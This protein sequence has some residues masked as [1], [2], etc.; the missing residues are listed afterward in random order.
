VFNYDIQ[1]RE[2]VRQNKII[3]EDIITAPEIIPL[4]PGQPPDARDLIRT[5]YY[6]YDPHKVSDIENVVYE[7]V[8]VN[9][10]DKQFFPLY[11]KDCQKIRSIKGK[12][13]NYFKLLQDCCDTFDCWI[14]PI[15]DRDLETGK[16]NYIETPVYTQTNVEKNEE[17]QIY[18]GKDAKERAL[19]KKIRWY[20]LR[21]G[22]NSSTSRI[23]REE[24]IEKINRTYHEEGEGDNKHLVETS[25]QKV[26]QIVYSPISGVTL[27]DEEK[28]ELKE[29]NRLANI[30]INLDV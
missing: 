1:S 19:D 21:F 15:I 18:V 20:E 28:I 11:D 3:I 22:F 6:I 8:G 17:P 24:E 4:F 9:P 7:Y 12:E 10:E 30:K 5:N 16:V 26:V 2:N 27:T 14:E 23:K 13:S 29:L 25:Q